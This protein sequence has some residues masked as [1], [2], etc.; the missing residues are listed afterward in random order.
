MVRAESG[1]P[2]T[3]LQKRSHAI[4]VTQQVRALTTTPGDLSSDLELPQ[5]IL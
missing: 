2:E 5:V 1:T 4:E 3:A